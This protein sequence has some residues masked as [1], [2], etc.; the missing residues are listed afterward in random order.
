MLPVEDWANSAVTCL[1]CA[2]SPDT[3]AAGASHSSQNLAL[4]RRPVPH[5]P[6][7]TSTVNPAK[8][9]QESDHP[10]CPQDRAYPSKRTALLTPAL[11]DAIDRRLCR[12]SVSPPPALTSPHGAPVAVGAVL[13]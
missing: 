11:S 13:P 10:D 3:A 2:V 5:D 4:S 9:I 8:P 12:V 7:A 6:H 1:Y